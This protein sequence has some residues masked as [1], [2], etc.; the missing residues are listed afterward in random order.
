MS[1]SPALKPSAF[2]VEESIADRFVD[3]FCAGVARLKI[4]NPM[5]AG[6]ISVQWRVAPIHPQALRIMERQAG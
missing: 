4:G 3:L 5:G 2:T 1:V 6:P